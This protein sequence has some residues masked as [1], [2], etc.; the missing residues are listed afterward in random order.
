MEK[1]LSIVI[2]TYN[3]EKYLHRCL[4][5]LIIRKELMNSL[6]VLIINDGSKDSSSLIAHN[7]QEKF[8]NTFRVI[9]KENENYGSCIN[10]GIIESKGLFFKILDA[11]DWYNKTDLE[12]L[13]E[14]IY[15]YGN[16]VDALYT[17][18]SYHNYNTN[19]IINYNF[20]TI[21]YEKILKL[22]DIPF[23]NSEDEFLLKMYSLTIKT[24]ILRE[25]KLCLDTGISYT[26][27]EYI[28]FTYP[29]LNNVVFLD[30]YV[31]QYFIGREGQTINAAITEKHLNDVLLIANRI[32]DNYYSITKTLL[33]R[34]N[35][36]NVVTN[37]VAQRCVAYFDQ[38]LNVSKNEILTSQISHLYEKIK[39]NKNLLFLVR[40]QSKGLRLWIY[41]GLYKSNIVIKIFLFLL[42]MLQK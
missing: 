35:T 27:N 20:K 17:N 14:G 6:D 12:K 11:D 9:D 31:Y 16:N 40:K 3:M 23:A 29:H 4:D 19:Q 32:L 39:N 26:D 30:I 33:E 8:P 21:K 38:A 13:I 25:I 2:P 37:M 22:K 24:N 1:V 10:R 7:Y 28:Y 5:S 15:K 36:Y 34:K 18:F 42:K 41:T